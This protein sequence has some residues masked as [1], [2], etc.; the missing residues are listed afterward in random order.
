MP[1]TTKQGFVEL[2]PAE[3]VDVGRA[4][5]FQ[6]PCDIKLDLSIANTLRIILETVKNIEE[7]VKSI[8]LEVKE[9]ESSICSSIQ[10]I[11]AK[12]GTMSG[13]IEAE[14]IRYDK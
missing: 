9:N 11:E 7:D 13:I 12:V 8:K 6:L 14:K 10:H 3:S 5:E 4:N 1:A 2:L